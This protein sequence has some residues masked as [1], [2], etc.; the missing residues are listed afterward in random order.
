MEKVNC[1]TWTNMN[2]TPSYILTFHKSED[3]KRKILI[4]KPL[5]VRDIVAD[6]Q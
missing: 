1:A 4:Q 3:Q 6:M 2:K 5:N